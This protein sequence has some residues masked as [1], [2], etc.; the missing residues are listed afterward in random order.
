MR[1]PGIFR[2]VLDSTIC[3]MNGRCHLPEKQRLPNFRHV[4]FFLSTCPPIQEEWQGASIDIKAAHKRMLIREEERGAL[5]FQFENRPTHTEQ[6]K[7]SAWHWGRVSGAILR[8]VHRLLYFRHAAWVY[9]DDFFFLFPNSTANIQFTLAVI[10]LRVIGA[11]LS[12]KKL[13]FDSFIEWPKFK[14]Q[15]FTL[16]IDTLLHHLCRKN[17]EEIIGI[18]LWATSMVHHTRF[19]LASLYRDLYAIPAA[20][21]SIHPTQW[22]YFL[23]ILNDDATISVHNS[24]H[25]PMGARIVEFKH[26]NSKR[27]LP[28]DIPNPRP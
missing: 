23:S 27:Q 5:L 28:T 4:S 8:L 12:W 16:L 13:E 22:E 18:I 9:V 20:N 3:G 2:L 10:L 1:T 15:T 17:L 25:L 24:L 7:T 21:Y 11:P 26:T 19:L 6:H 14:L